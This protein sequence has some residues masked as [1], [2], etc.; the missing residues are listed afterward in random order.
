MST[1]LHVPLKGD[2]CLE[3]DVS[4][5]KADPSAC[6]KLNQVSI[7]QYF[8]GTAGSMDRQQVFGQAV[9]SREV[10][11]TVVALF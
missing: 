2:P 8:I 10:F 4:D 1:P 11:A 7:L 9:L 6:L 3:G 5:D